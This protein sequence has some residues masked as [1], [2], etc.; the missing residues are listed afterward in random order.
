MLS[1]TVIYLLVNGAFYEVLGF[2][3]MASSEAV[4]VTFAS[5]AWGT[6]MAVFVPLAI[7]V[8]LFGTTCGQSFSNSRLLL[9]AARQGHLPTVLS[10][11]NVKS[12]VPTAAMLARGLVAIVFALSGSVNF[13]IETSVFIENAWDIGSVSALLLLRRSLPNMRRPFRVPTCIAWIRLLV[14]VAVAVAPLTQGERYLPQYGVIFGTVLCGVAYY[15]TFVRFRLVLPGAA[16]V[17]ST[18]QKCLNS[19]AC[20]NE[21]DRMLTHGEERA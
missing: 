6:K 18:V 10:F 20:Y 8:T 11:I 17:T 14:C 2:S 3:G 4:A 21:L 16:S 12:R 1:T 5:V 13:L 19:A 15:F 7:S 9:A